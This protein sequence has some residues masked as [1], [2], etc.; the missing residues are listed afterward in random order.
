MTYKK[1]KIS[2]ICF[3][4]YLTKL[5]TPPEG[6][7]VVQ[8]ADDISIYISGTEIDKMTDS[9]N[10]YIDKV[11][12]FLEER[13][14]Q[15]SPEK[16]TVTLFTPDPAQARLEPKVKM[17]NKQVKLDKSPKLL[18]V[19]FDTMHSFS[20]H[21]DYTVDKAKKK[22]NILKCL[23]GTDWGQD[24][25]TMVMTYKAVIRSILEYAAPIWNPIISAT[26][27]TKLQRAQNQAL[28]IAT[29]CHSITCPDHLHRESKV[30]PLKEHG[31]M[32][33]KQ[34]LT[35]CH[36]PIHPGFKH[37]NMPQP[38]RAMKNTMLIYEKSTRYY[39]DLYDNNRKLANQQIH[40]DSVTSA[41]A[42]Y[43]P[44]RVLGVPPLVSTPLF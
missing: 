26:S 7:Q 35:Q 2:P 28:R 1:Y 3:N 39:L 44:N 29:G 5:P 8:Y 20:K 12:D 23:A 40:T 41:L 31:E 16:S 34:Y 42:N 21:I 27:W 10:L 15:V 14:L 18:G 33:T 30:L 22:L 38:P 13:E 37:L 17:R 32:L 36:N 43:K 4:Y 11:L 9:I 6:I 24:Q 25:E 19:H